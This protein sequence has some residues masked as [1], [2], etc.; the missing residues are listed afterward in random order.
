M[1][2]VPSKVQHDPLITLGWAMNIVTGSGS[3]VC[4]SRVA[5]NVRNFKVLGSL[6]LHQNLIQASHV[7][8]EGT[9]NVS[10]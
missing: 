6:D 3:I 1:E 8:G 4:Q 7:N 5:K 10:A 2:R 9:L